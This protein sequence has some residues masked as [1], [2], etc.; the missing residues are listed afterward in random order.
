[1]SELK[2]AAE[3]HI[4]HGKLIDVEDASG[5]YAG[6]EGVMSQLRDEGT[7]IDFAV[8]LL[9]P[10]PIDRT[11]IRSLGKPNR[12]DDATIVKFSDK[13]KVCWEIHPIEKNE[14]VNAA[15]L[16]SRYFPVTTRGQL[17]MLCTALGIEL[18]E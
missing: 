5:L 12:D 16:E 18:K 13:L 1:V 11:W 14:T 6:D 2:Q 10:T 9:D 4:A 7:L 15:I 8:K 3:R 17:R